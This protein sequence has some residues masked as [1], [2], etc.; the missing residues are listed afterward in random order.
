MVLN[1]SLGTTTTDDEPPIA[2][3]AAVDLIDELASAHPTLDA[4]IVA[5]AGNYGTSRIVWPAGFRGVIAVGA[6]TQDLRPAPWSSYGPWVDCS[7]IGDGVLSVYVEGREDPFFDTAADTFGPNS[8]ALHF[9]TSF[10]APQV[11][12]LVAQIAAVEGIWG[13]GGSSPGSAGWPAPA[14]CGRSSLRSADGTAV[15]RVRGGC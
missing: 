5:A 14:G 6:L 7:V 2:L 13:S 8:W 4:L 11:A 1:L 3:Q 12:G 15:R 10:A 9:G